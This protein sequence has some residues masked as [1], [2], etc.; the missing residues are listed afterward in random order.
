MRSESSTKRLIGGVIFLVALGWV[1][2]GFAQITVG[3]WL[4]T[5]AKGKGITMTA[6]PCC[7]GGRR[8]TYHIPAMG[9]QPPSTLTVESRMDGT[10]APALVDGKPSGE[11]IAIKR[12]DDRHYT[13][14]IKMS[15]RQFGTST[16]TLSADGKTLTVE[17]VMDVGGKPEKET[18]V[19]Q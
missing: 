8:L 15:G 7:N 16:A 9:N 4:R 17:S 2:Q 10:D 11:T 6:E 14:V 18:W 1:S 19:K 13:S 5:D 12:V 3:T